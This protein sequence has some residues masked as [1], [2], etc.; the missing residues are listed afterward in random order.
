M[1]ITVM[2]SNPDSVVGN[3]A[4]YI[5]TSQG[6]VKSEKNTDTEDLIIG[7]HQATAEVF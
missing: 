7:R 3:Q 5:L 1:K 4:E 2:R 6:M